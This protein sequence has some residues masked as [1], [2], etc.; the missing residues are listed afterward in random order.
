[1]MFERPLWID[2]D[3]FASPSTHKQPKRAYFELQ[4]MSKVLCKKVGSFGRVS[5]SRH[6][7]TSANHASSDAHDA[8]NYDMR[9][10]HP[11]KSAEIS[12]TDASS[13]DEMSKSNDCDSR[14]HYDGEVRS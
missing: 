1:M 9:K 4:K 3:A 8:S 2:E 5:E 10:M 6:L 14:S 12:G 11:I 7:P 13:D